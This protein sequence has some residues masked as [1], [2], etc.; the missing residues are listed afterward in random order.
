VL[1]RMGRRYLAA[2]Y[3]RIVGRIRDAVPNA[4]VHADVIAG[5]PTE[6]ERAHRRTLQ[7]IRALELAG[8][9]VFRYSARPGTPATRMLGQVD[10]RTKRS[11]AAALLALGAEAR[12]AF[13]R[14]AVGT[15]SLVLVE[16]RLPDGRWIGH[17]EDHVVVA[18]RPR[19]GDPRELENAILRVRRTAPDPRAPDRVEGEILA[20][21]P[22]PR[23]L[24][25]AVP[26]IA[27]FPNGGAHA[28]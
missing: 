24:R 13:A 14:R 26:V 16:T 21:D 22:A 20:V 17:A 28:P 11:R 5:F 7:R 8:L 4:A 6:D 19:P 27:S 3:T 25:A 10:E 9:H 15:E 2:E 1:R 23:A 18:V 12:A